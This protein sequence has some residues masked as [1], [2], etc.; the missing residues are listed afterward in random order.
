M[1]SGKGYDRT[2]DGDFGD[3]VMK[4]FYTGRFALEYKRTLTVGA[5]VVYILVRREVKSDGKDVSRLF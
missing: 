2:V 5:K 1:P 4:S 3:I